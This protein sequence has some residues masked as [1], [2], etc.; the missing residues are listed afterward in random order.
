MQTLKNIFGGKFNR[1]QYIGISV[2]VI[3]LMVLNID[4]IKK[5]DS[6]EDLTY[7]ELGY[8][9]IIVFSQ[10]IASAKRLRDIGRSAWWSL[11]TFVPPLNSVMLILLMFIPG[12]KLAR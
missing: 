11:L 7:P 10:M 6:G 12:K 5:L 2:A 3:G 9:A 4:V 1:F 8:L